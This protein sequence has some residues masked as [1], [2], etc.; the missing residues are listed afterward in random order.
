MSVCSFFFVSKRNSAR[1]SCR[2]H[3]YIDADSCGRIV[4]LFSFLHNCWWLACSH[5]PPTPTYSKPSEPLFIMHGMIFSSFAALVLFCIV[6]TSTAPA[7]AESSAAIS[8]DNAG[9]ESQGR[10]TIGRR[11]RKLVVRQQADN[12]DFTASSTRSLLQGE[13]WAVACL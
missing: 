13:G 2:A 1:V 8:A 12:H 6:A 9:V 7:L 5:A 10:F 4:L 11:E 3:C